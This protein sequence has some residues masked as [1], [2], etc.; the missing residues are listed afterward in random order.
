MMND[1][2]RLTQKTYADV[3]NLAE[4][5]RQHIEERKNQ[6]LTEQ[7][8][9]IIQQVAPILPDDDFAN[10]INFASREVDDGFSILFSGTDK[11]AWD[12]H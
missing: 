12:H 1:S 6:E 8:Q 11:E 3:T 10:S 7:I 9:A 5:V 4:T 2:S